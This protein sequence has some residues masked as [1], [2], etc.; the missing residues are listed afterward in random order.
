MLGVAWE[1]AQSVIG[2]SEA[3]LQPSSY[4]PELRCA[5]DGGEGF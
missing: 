4:V 1:P 2:Q 5:F 3:V